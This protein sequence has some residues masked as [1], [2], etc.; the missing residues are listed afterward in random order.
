MPRLA[1]MA[2]QLMERHDA[3]T[4]DIA[5]ME[6][7][8]AAALLDGQPFDTASLMAK[9]GELMVLQAAQ[10]EAERRE[11]A[12]RIVAE[13]ARKQAV[14]VEIDKTLTAHRDA[15]NDAQKAAQTLVAAL[16]AVGETGKR[17]RGHAGALGHRPPLALDNAELDRAMSRLIGQ[18]LGT[19]GRGRYGYLTW[20]GGFPCAWADHFDRNVKPEFDRMTGALPAIEKDHDNGSNDET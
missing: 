14:A 13:T 8:S 10:T 4:A 2:S 11:H 19:V 17:L 12:E 5:T 7:E 1:E 3:L 16:T 18:E 20:P 9:H 15:V 6:R